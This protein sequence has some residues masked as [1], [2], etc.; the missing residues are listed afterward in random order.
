[1]AD[2]KSVKEPK[3]LYPVVVMVPLGNHRFD[4]VVGDVDLDAVRR[5]VVKHKRIHT[6]ELLQR[7]RE[8][9]SEIDKEAL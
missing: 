8:L 4:V 3:K 5:Q 7:A 6:A 2:G 9:V 1:M